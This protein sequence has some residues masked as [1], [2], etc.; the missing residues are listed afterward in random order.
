M[1]SSA[2]FCYHAKYNTCKIFLTIVTCRISRI[3]NC[4]CLL[5]SLGEA[6]GE[7][8]DGWDEDNTDETDKD[9]ESLRG[10]H[11]DTDMRL[12]WGLSFASK[13][14]YSSSLVLVVDKGSFTNDFLKSRVNGLGKRPPSGTST[15][16]KFIN[17]G[18]DCSTLCCLCMLDTGKHGRLGREQIAGTRAQVRCVRRLYNKDIWCRIVRRPMIAQRLE[19][20]RTC[21]VK[22]GERMRL[23]CTA[24]NFRVHFGTFFLLTWPI[25]MLVV[26]AKTDKAQHAAYFVQY[27][28]YFFAR[29]FQVVASRACR[30]YGALFSSTSVTVGFL[31]GNVNGGRVGA[32]H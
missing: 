31:A 7:T 11:L 16:K 12:A 23:A 6:T 27:L 22:S 32:G 25:L 19:S 28:A 14:K 20:V 2:K 18:G 24:L 21:L 15:D 3:P 17:L 30:V 4:N 10:K 29:R 5:L 9:N 1:L 13:S 26:F 8:E